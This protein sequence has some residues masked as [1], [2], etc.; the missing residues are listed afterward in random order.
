[1]LGHSYDITLILLLLAGDALVV[2]IVNG[3]E[4]PFIVKVQGL[5]PQGHACSLRAREGNSFC[6]CGQGA[7]SPGYG[8]ARKQVR[9]LRF[10]PLYLVTY[11]PTPRKLRQ[12]LKGIWE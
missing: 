9:A 10:L 4:I 5:R 1:M 11:P 8:H 7:F 6:A 2:V 12:C 3:R